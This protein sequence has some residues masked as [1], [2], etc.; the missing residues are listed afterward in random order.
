VRVTLDDPNLLQ[1]WDEVGAT[2][3]NGKWHI[4]ITLLRALSTREQV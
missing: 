1:M 4:T 2:S 3:R